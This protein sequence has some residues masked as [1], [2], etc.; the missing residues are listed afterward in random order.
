[1][2][3]LSDKIRL[4]R[5]IISGSPVFFRHIGK[6]SPAAS[7][8]LGACLDHFDHHV[9]RL[10][11]HI[12]SEVGADTERH[13]DT[14]LTKGLNTLDFLRRQRIREDNRLAQRVDAQTLVVRNGLRSKID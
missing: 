5:A 4:A 8:A 6:R 2:F 1:M 3:W 14:F 7:P 13:A 11:A 12:V 9:H 10:N